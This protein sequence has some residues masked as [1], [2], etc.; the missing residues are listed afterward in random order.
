MRRCL[1]LL[2]LMGLGASAYAAIPVR[3]GMDGFAKRGAWAPVEIGPLDAGVVRVDVFIDEKDYRN[4][5]KSIFHV[6]ARP[7]PETGIVQTRILVPESAS[8]KL[9]I[10][11]RA[12]RR[13]DMTET[14]DLPLERLLT[15]NDRLVLIVS[16]RPADFDFLNGLEPGQRGMVTR[17]VPC[18]QGAFPDRW[19][20]LALTDV[21]ILDGDDTEPAPRQ[22]EVLA[23]WIAHGGTLVITADGLAS[24]GKDAWGLAGAVRAGE[25][26][27]CS[28][29]MLE[30]L[31]GGK[32]TAALTDIPARTL[33]A[34]VPER[35]VNAGSNVVV[36][37]RDYGAGRILVTTLDWRNIGLRDR[38][39]YETVRRAIWTRLLELRRPVGPVQLNR[40]L[41]IPREA[42]ASFLAPILIVFLAL[43]VILVGPV[44]WLVLR[45][46]RRMELNVLTLPVGAAIFTLLAFAI[47]FTLRSPR[48][49]V[50]EAEIVAGAP[51]APALAYRIGGILSPDHSDYLVKQPDPDAFLDEYS[52]YG[53]Y[54]GA[55]A[56]VPL[57]VYH[58]DLDGTRVGNV[59]IGTWAMRF[60]KMQSVG[61]KGVIDARGTCGVTNILGR[62][63]N[64]STFPLHEAIVVCRGN[65]VR[66]GTL[67]PGGETA[68][69]LALL[70]MSAESGL[71]PNCHRYHGGQR[72]VFC[73]DKLINLGMAEEMAELYG[74]VVEQGAYALE[75]VVIGRESVTGS[76]MTLDRPRFTMNR[77]RVHVAP[78]R[79]DFSGKEVFVPEEIAFPR[80][81]S[82]SR[83]PLVENRLPWIAF[84]LQSM[85]PGYWTAQEAAAKKQVRYE[86]QEVVQYP[87]SDDEVNRTRQYDCFLPFSADRMDTRSLVV[88]WDAGQAHPDYDPA[89]AALS[90]YEWKSGTWVE[91]CR[92]KSGDH[93]VNVQDPGRFVRLPLA[94]VRVKV[95][96]VDAVVN[97]AVRYP[98]VMAMG[99]AYAGLRLEGPEL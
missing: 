44:N 34:P 20:D 26:V 24:G 58:A 25:Q 3:I 31:F 52:D 6:T 70:P 9:F 40:D 7:S 57:K 2:L 68:F 15:R 11:C 67:A 78:V 13:D 32:D 79:L 27:T 41:V 28:A 91:L 38:A 53:F 43:Y 42:R 55:S 76:V 69:D 93:V 36:A 14:R 60:F 71:C 90:I 96:A 46:L 23:A 75:P 72:R 21:V 22:R 5:R 92:A 61:A 62:V 56:K 8:G 86:Y 16:R 35:M 12:T 81:M 33:D 37:G 18:K 47:G 74:Q 39:A 64:L 63:R 50:Q 65:F 94:T 89:N 95:A 77:T 88:H 48:P 51:E 85:E 29:Q 98:Q 99:V 59:R 54:Q 1:I 49:L 4:I 10:R 45:K 30:P 19:Q 83:N 73:R 84:A 82:P 87:D 97:G 17:A 66:I 80:I